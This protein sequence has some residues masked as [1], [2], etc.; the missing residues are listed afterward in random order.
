M[1]AARLSIQEAER[2]GALEG[3]PLEL[4]L[5]RE[6][7]GK[8]KEALFEEHFT[9]ARRHADLAVVNAEL[10]RAKAE[11]VENLEATESLMGELD[12]L[13][14]DLDAAGVVPVVDPGSCRSF[15]TA[16][17]ARRVDARGCR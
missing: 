14:A 10:A 15:S 1:E 13:R 9:K 2:Q 12:T 16:S 8:A 3:A 11:T 6:H 4:F 7:L 17:H 5:A